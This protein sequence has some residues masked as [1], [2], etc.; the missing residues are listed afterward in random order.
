MEGL[1]EIAFQII[2]NVGTAKSLYIEAIGKAKT[3]DFEG[4][5]KMVKDGDDVF[6]EGHHAHAK[7]LEREA[8]GKDT[9]SLLIM[10]AEDQMMSAEA[11]KN[12]A[13]EFI[14]TY[15]EIKDLKARLQKVEA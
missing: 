3:G 2:S 6:I 4:A 15:H 8:N 12:I 10:H 13:L 11:F 1:E 5:E 14:D 9:L 7:L